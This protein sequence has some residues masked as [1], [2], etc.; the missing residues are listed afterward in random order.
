MAASFPRRARHGGFT[1]IELLVA[2]AVIIILAGLVIMAGEGLMKVGGRNRAKAEIAAISSALEAYKTDNGIY[3]QDA[4]ITPVTQYSQIDP[5]AGVGGQYQ[6]AATT[7]Y[8]ALSGKNNYAD[9]SF[10][11]DSANNLSNKSY[12]NFPS[13]ELGNWKTGG[14]ANTY[15]Q[16]PFGYPYGYSTGV[17]VNG[18]TT[19]PNNGAGNFDLW[20]T[21][22]LTPQSTQLPAG[23]WTAAWIQNW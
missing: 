15:V 23:G 5:S 1:L 2:I 16:D 22:G 19:P 7:L 4:N 6:T 10:T 21:G 8:G 3:P 14:G 13:R 12:M 11:Y 18:A 20:S 17:G 9:T